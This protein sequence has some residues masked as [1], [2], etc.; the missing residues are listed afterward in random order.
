MA[1]ITRRIAPPHG[2]KRNY[3]SNCLRLSPHFLQVRLRGQWKKKRQPVWLQ[4]FNLNFFKSLMNLCKIRKY[5][6]D[7]TGLEAKKV[8]R[9]MPIECGM[10]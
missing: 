8:K 4:P 5:L 7:K 1:E 9:N 2:R 6:A 10:T 3:R